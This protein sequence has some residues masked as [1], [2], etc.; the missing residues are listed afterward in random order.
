[1]DFGYITASVL[2]VLLPL[3]CHIELNTVLVD[4]VQ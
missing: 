2:M 1:M 4:V 3:T